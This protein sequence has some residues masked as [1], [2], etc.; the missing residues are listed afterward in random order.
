MI[1]IYRASD[2]KEFCI[3]DKCIEHERNM[4]MRQA[5]KAY[6]DYVRYRE[7]HAKIFSEYLFIKQRTYKDYERPADV[8]SNT[9]MRKVYWR[10]RKERKA[11]LKRSEER[12]LRLKKEWRQQLAE[13]KKFCKDG[14]K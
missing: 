9:Q 2:G 3:K 13:A 6:I 5:D 7:R 1:V 8:S 4:K 11:E 12:L 10:E 14:E